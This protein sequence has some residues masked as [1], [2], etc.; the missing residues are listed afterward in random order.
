MQSQSVQHSRLDSLLQTFLGD[1]EQVSLARGSH[2]KMPG[3]E[4][5]IPDKQIEQESQ[6]SFF[7]ILK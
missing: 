7:W 5:H 2:P 4:V 3:V 1:R 6:S